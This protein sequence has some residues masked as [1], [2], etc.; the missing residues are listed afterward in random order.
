M[1][2]LSQALVYL[3]LL[4]NNPSL[5]KSEGCPTQIRACRCYRHM[6][7]C[8]ALG[9]IRHLPKVTNSSY[10]S[11]EKFNFFAVTKSIWS[12]ILPGAFENVQFE[13]CN[14][15]CRENGIAEEPACFFLSNPS[16]LSFQS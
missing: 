8:S 4:L 11:L 13:V 7:Y 14:V 3:L 5:V 2:R 15:L 16:D 1:M 6:I 10:R 12:T 9:D